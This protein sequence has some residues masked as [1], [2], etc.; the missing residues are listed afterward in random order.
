[1]AILKVGTLN[2][3]KLMSVRH[4][5]GE[6]FDVYGYKV[7]SGVPSQPLT[8]EETKQGAVN[9]AIYLIEKEKADIA[10]GLE[11]GV[12]VIN[13]HYFLCNWGALVT[14]AGCAFVAGGARIPLPD[15]VVG[16]LKEGMEL[17]DVMDHYANKLNVRKNEGAVGI[18]TN[19][20]VTRSE[21]FSHINRLLKG[22]FE[23]ANMSS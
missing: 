1:M 18:L 5:F 13:T 11:G 20:Q 19:L 10:L 3:A 15:E 12:M 22:Q 4:V 2:E 9:R 6:T 8:D 23:R 16:S 17:G 14:N 21:M 7:P